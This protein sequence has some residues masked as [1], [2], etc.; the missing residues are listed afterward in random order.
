MRV[1]ASDYDGT[2]RI[3]EKVTK[4]DLE[5]LARWREAGNLFV[6]VTGRSMESFTREIAENG[7]AC[8]YIIANN[9]GVIYDGKMNRMQVNYMDFDRA[10]ALIGYIRT[11][12]C[13]SYVIN[14]GYYRHRIVV[15]EQEEDLKYGKMPQEKNEAELLASGV[16][17]AKMN[18]VLRG[19]LDAVIKAPSVNTQPALM[20]LAGTLKDQYR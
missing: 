12:P 17:A 5:A 9:G 8:D 13:A 3:E 11:L 1:L 4:A 14:D 19:L 2:L 7:F 6:A 15:N 16:P 18:R 20:M 10:M